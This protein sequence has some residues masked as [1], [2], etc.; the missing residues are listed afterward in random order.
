MLSNLWP[1]AA[2]NAAEDLSEGFGFLVWTPPDVIF[3]SNES[4]WSSSLSQA[5]TETS[6]KALGHPLIAL[7]GAY[8]ES[9]MVR[10][11]ALNAG[12][13]DCIEFRESPGEAEAKVFALVRRTQRLQVKFRKAG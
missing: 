7:V 5:I 6:A 10:I 11:A 1:D 4:G 3:V 2:V 12:A 13:D 9:D 8:G